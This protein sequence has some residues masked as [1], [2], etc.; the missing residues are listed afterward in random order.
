MKKQNKK[1]LDVLPKTKNGLT[2]FKSTNE[3]IFNN[4]QLQQ[5]VINQSF[6]LHDVLIKNKNKI[7]NT[8]PIKLSESAFLVVAFDITNI[9]K[10]QETFEKNI[11]SLISFVI[12]MFSIIWF[13]A[14]K[15][16]LK[17]K[18]QIANELQKSYKIISENVLYSNTDLNGVITEAS[19]A[20]CR[21]SGYT[22]GQLIGSPHSI[23]RH[24]DTKNSVYD[25]L[26]STIKANKIW[27]GEVKNLKP[28]GSFYWATSTI[29]PRFDDSGKKIGYMAI[30][31]DITD[32][33]II[34]ANSITDSLC[35]IF[36]R[37][38]FDDVFQKIINVAKRKNES[39]CF[40]V[41]DVDYFKQYNDAYGHQM[42]D[43]A[44][45]IIAKT[46]K[47]SLKR[48]DDSCFRLGGEEFGIIFK[49][50]NK[51]TALDFANRIRTNIENLKIP[52]SESNVSNYIT[53]SFGVVFKRAS[54]I[55][56][57]DAIYKDADDL[58][59]KAKHKSR[60]TVIINE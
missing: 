9:I 41:M 53:A 56:D 1:F 19:D 22:Q 16:Y 26:W 52:H 34:E 18:V 49:T 20:F 5:D 39:I 13:F 38:H 50:E 35:N 8:T 43:N 33:K 46:L 30:K 17:N 60:N 40:L 54:D 14:T 7:F 21:S 4:Y 58:L 3:N 24:P 12:I 57:A 10:E 55:K 51:E 23:V 59:Y 32:R 11:T 31:Q 48:G 37:R 45:K 29:S 36:N 47:Q 2:I 6:D 42:G 25:D 44:L 27:K 28:D 15:L